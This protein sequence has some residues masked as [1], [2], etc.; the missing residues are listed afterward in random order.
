[1]T[2]SSSPLSYVNAD[3]SVAKRVFLRML[4]TAYGITDANRRYQS[5]RGSVEEYGGWA[6]TRLLEACDI[7]LNI[8]AAQWPPIR[9]QSRPLVV[10]A[11]HPFGVPDGI[12]ILAMAEQLGRPFRILI[13]ND[14]LRI[15]EIA[16]Y[17][18]PI[19][20]SETRE[21]VRT[22]IES[23]REAIQRLK[24]GEIIVIF[25]SGGV[26][27]ARNPFG[28]AEDLPWKTFTAKLIHQAQADVIPLY[29]EGQNS[30]LFH[31]VSRVSM[32]LRL[33]MIVPEATR[34]IGNPIRLHVGS[35]I[36]YAEIAPIADRQTLIDLLRRRV[37]ALAP[38]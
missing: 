24:S 3:M 25:P 2:L 30:F 29:F 35:L 11:N 16:R 19:D 17:S 27:T 23:G 21:A 28:R 33:S 37:F 34:R 26:A 12:A 22:N 36:P 14:L 4:E 6:M 13:N 32:F 5:W 9:D 10:I 20:F 8:N 15:P 31:A 18:L 1:M 38:V 7:A